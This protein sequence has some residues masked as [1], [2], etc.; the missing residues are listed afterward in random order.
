MEGLKQGLDIS[1]LWS[2]KFLDQQLNRY[3][4]PTQ[5]FSNVSS[6]SVENVSLDTRH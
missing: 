2:V 3:P 5:I 6:S 4:N 1:W